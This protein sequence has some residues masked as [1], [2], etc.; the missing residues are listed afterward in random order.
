[1]TSTA[2][3][4]KRLKQPK[5]PTRNRFAASQK[6]LH[7]LRLTKEDDERVRVKIRRMSAL[8]SDDFAPCPPLAR[9]IV[10]Y[11]VGQTAHTLVLPEKDSCLPESVF[12][13]LRAQQRGKK[14]EPWWTEEEEEE[15]EEEEAGIRCELRAREKR[16]LAVGTFAVAGERLDGQ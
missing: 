12:P 2:S 9:Y 8:R 7:L 6:I 16:N 4:F 13:R 10:V 3:T 14:L 5:Q 15:E 11:S 1:M